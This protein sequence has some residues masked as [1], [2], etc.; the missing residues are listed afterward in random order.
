[1]LQV[2]RGHPSSALLR[3]SQLTLMQL[4]KNRRLRTIAVIQRLRP[5]ER[6]AQSEVE[7]KPV[8]VP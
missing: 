5:R 1:M 2:S 4:P 7:T 3:S 8:L 6:D